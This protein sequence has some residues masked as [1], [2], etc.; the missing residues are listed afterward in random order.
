MLP[1]DSIWG[2]IVVEIF[3]YLSLEAGR[4]HTSS[5]TQDV[6]AEHNAKRERVSIVIARQPRDQAVNLS[7]PWMGSFLAT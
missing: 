2:E 4:K 3:S 5:Y 1:R 7:F 6:E